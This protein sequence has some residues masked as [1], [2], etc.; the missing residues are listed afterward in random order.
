[1]VKNLSD[2]QCCYLV[3]D[4]PLKVSNLV[5]IHQKIMISWIPTSASIKEK[6]S[7]SLHKSK[8][9][10]LFSGLQHDFVVDSKEEVT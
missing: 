5:I 10:S 4:F 2:K 1:L 9:I 7:Y 6:L 8:V 3:I